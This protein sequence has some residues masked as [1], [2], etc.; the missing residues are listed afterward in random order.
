MKEIY[1]M[2]GAGRS[3]RE[4][5]RELE[6]SRNTVRRYLKSPE[7]MRSKLR[8]RRGSKLDPYTEYID[9]RMS[10][11]LEN[12]VVLHREL[13]GLGHDG[14]YSILKGYVS[15]WRRQ[16]QPEATLR[17]ETAPGEQAQVD[18]GS[19]SYLGEDGK[20]YR[21]WV[22]VMTMGWSRACYV[23]LVRKADTA[24]FIQCHVFE[25]TQAL[26]LY[27]AYQGKIAE[28]DR[29]IEAQLERFEDRSDGES[30]AANGKKRNQKN[31][32]RFDA[33]SHPHRMT[34]VD[35][36][37]IDGVDAD[38]ALKVTSEIGTDLSKWPSAQHFASWLGLS[39]NNRITG[40]KVISSRT[41]PNAHRAALALRLAANALHRSDSARGAFLRRKKAQLGAPQGHH[42]HG[43]QA[44]QNHLL[45]AE[46]WPAIRGRRRRILRQP[47]PATGAP[48]RQT[49]SSAARL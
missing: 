4:I 47:V 24:A 21:V 7:A 40:G 17:F 31:A 13:R 46:V 8:R 35:L 29:E 9:R 14:G 33:Q 37:Q 34:G 12:C 1:E 41:K 42:G 19:L 6:V 3:I 32:P 30:P 45:D 39:P 22:L 11:G 10:E 38:T 15:P 27:Q 23:E 2:N 43:P 25:L 16:R 26:E 36:T 20:K 48:L 49:Q 18:W 5:A 28:C 44:G